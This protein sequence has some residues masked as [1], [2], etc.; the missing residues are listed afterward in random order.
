MSI[1]VVK[2]VKAS[3]EAQGV[4]LSGN[5]G[6]FQIT[7]RVAWI[8]RG[9]GYGLLGGKNPA[10]NGCATH[11]DKFAIDWILKADGHGVDILGDA[12][13]AN[14]PQWSE[15]EA[16]PAFYRPAFD[17]G[18]APVPPDPPDP[19][20]PPPATVCLFNITELTLKVNTLNAKVDALH[21]QAVANA[22][23]LEK[24]K[25]SLASILERQDRVYT[26]RTA[27]FGGPVVLTPR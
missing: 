15:D 20:D 6:A 23:S 4:D 13:G 19:P 17:P 18:D 2:A 10:Q 3:L 1:E 26:G 5:C 27:A 25:M 7:Q 21:D 22:E 16:D 12:G 9:D 24:M 8:L 14:N 11:G